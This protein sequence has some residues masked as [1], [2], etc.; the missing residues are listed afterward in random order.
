MNE[1]L[2]V[3]VRVFFMFIFHISERGKADIYQTY[4]AQPKAHRK[5]NGEELKQR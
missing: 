5:K 4:R 1:C 3:C 2:C